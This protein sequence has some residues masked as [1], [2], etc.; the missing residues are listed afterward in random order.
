MG[1]PWFIVIYTY[2]TYTYTHCFYMYNLYIHIFIYIVF[3]ET[4]TLLDSILGNPALIHS[5]LGK[6]AAMAILSMVCCSSGFS[7][8]MTPFFCTLHLKKEMQRVF[9]SLFTV[10]KQLSPLNHQDVRQFY[11]YNPIHYHQPNV[12]HLH[13]MVPNMCKSHYIVTP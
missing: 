9:L 13:S 4:K 6:S 11:A 5:S 12:K 1:K 8:Q 2:T 10:S 7:I 3:W